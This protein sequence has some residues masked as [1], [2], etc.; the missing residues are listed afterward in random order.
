MEIWLFNLP[1]TLAFAFYILGAVLAMG[2]LALGE[3]GRWLVRGS[4]AAIALGAAAHTFIIGHRWVV[5]GHPP[6]SGLFD[7]VIFFSWT[8][9]VVFGIVEIAFRTRWLTLFV[10]LTEIAFFLYAWE[11]DPAI[12]PLVP[13]LKSAWLIIHVFCYMIGYGVMTVASFMAVCYY[14][15][16]LRGGGSETTQRFD[17]LTYRLVAFGFPL[18]T[19]GVLTGAVWANRTWGRYWGWDPKE[20]WSLVSWI[21]Y[22]TFLHLR[23]WSRFWKL[24]PEGRQ[25]VLNWLPILGLGAIVFTFLLLKYLPSASQS[26]HTYM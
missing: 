21:I 13:V 15:H 1:F 16:L 23:Y 19:A 18:L 20:T 11:C 25:A 5:S 3:R 14:A 10:G 7:A 6:L 17:T 8:T 4:Y 9:V 22:A 26:L 24:S 2:A 12:K